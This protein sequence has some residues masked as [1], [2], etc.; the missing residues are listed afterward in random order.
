MQN[1]VSKEIVCPFYKQEEGL[2]LRCEGFSKYCSLQISFVSRQD[3]KDHENTFCK[4]IRKY[5]ECPI[6]PVVYHQYEDNKKQ[7]KDHNE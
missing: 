2:K 1:Y 3:L 4:S 7:G 6:Y 5:P